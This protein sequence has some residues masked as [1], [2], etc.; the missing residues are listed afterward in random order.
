MLYALLLVIIVLIALALSAQWLWRESTDNRRALS[1][2]FF[3]RRGG[4]TASAVLKRM[5][6]AWGNSEPMPDL[7]IVVPRTREIHETLRASAGSHRPLLV[8]LGGD[9]TREV[10]Y[11]LWLDGTQPHETLVPFSA[12]KGVEHVQW[13]EDPVPASAPDSAIVLTVDADDRSHRLVLPVE[14]D[15]GLRGKELERRLSDFIE[16]RERP[17]A[18]PVVLR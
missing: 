14:R 3:L 5:R 15:W 2:W 11:L 7:I 6:A 10:L 8:G 9:S 12:V 18:A 13:D 17:T 1:E 16:G 4:L